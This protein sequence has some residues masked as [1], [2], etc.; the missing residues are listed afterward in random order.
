MSCE[1][2]LYDH[3]ES[4]RF[5]RCDR[6]DTGLTSYLCRERSV[7]RFDGT[8]DTAWTTNHRQTRRFNNIY[9][10]SREPGS[11]RYEDTDRQGSGSGRVRVRAQ[12]RRHCSADREQP[13]RWQLQLCH[14]QAYTLADV[15]SKTYTVVEKVGTLG[16]VTYATNS[17]TVNVTI[18]DKGDG[19]LN[20]VVTSENAE[21]LDFT[22]TYAAAGSLDLS[23][24]KTLTGRILFAN[25]VRVWQL[26]E[27]STLLDTAHGMMPMEMF[28]L[29]PR[30]TTHWLTLA[31]RPIPWSQ[32]LSRRVRL[33]DDRCNQFIY[34]QCHDHSDKGER[35]LGNVVVT[36]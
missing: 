24:T 8:L 13:G 12:G 5:G 16:G 35:H 1:H 7:T 19:T 30:S 11:V 31:A 26:Y 36:E 3:R 6:I 28:S 9:A 4:Q 33:D 15:G 29:Q 27:D 20:V 14:D 10:A 21:D 22:N 18:S 23:G 34:R 32:R 25:A 17:Y 2:V